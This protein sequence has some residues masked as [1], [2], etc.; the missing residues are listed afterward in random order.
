MAFTIRAA[1][2]CDT[3]RIRSNN[4]DNFLFRGLSLR[5]ENSALS[6]VLRHSCTTE[7]KQLYAVFDGMGGEN[8]GEAAAFAAAKAAYG[9]SRR[10]DNLS[11]DF[12]N[13]AVLDINRAV[14]RAAQAL[15]TD[16]MGATLAM[17]GFE[18][19]S[20]WVCNLGDSRIFLLR[21]DA[22]GQLSIDHTDEKELLERGIRR[23]PRLT[24]HLGINPEEMLVEPHIAAGTLE[25]GDRFLICSDGLTDMLVPDEIGTALAEIPEPADCAAALVEQ[26]LA[27]GGKDNVTVIVCAVEA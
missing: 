9:I 17:I 24:Q 25:P 3:G 23:K 5:Q 19:N 20:A 11:E 2:L 13:R 27:R 16:R 1:C 15:G 22:F 18:E 6:T 14:F 12:L 21:G 7:K 10:E 4:E 26:A 8:H